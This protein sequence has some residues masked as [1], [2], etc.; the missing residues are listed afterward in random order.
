MSN[1]TVLYKTVDSKCQK[2]CYVIDDLDDDPLQIVDNVVTIDTY[3]GLRPMV[4]SHAIFC[5]SINV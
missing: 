4:V 5:L 1:K 3:K 2:F